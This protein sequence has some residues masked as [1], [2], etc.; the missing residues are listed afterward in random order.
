MLLEVTSKLLTCQ[1]GYKRLYFQKKGAVV[2]LNVA[3]FLVLGGNLWLDFINTE[4]VEHGQPK[5]LVEN[6]ADLVAWAVATHLLE[7][8]G[9]EHLAAVWNDQHAAGLWPIR[10]FRS[11]L[12]SMAVGLVQGKAVDAAIIAAINEE[13]RHK[14]GIV[15]VRQHES[16]FEK[17]FHPMIVEPQQLLAP[18]AES[19]ADFLCYANMAYLKKC[20]NP[21][22]ILYF[23][24]TTKN[25]SRR[26]CSM[27]NCGNRA[28]V[29]AF[30]QRRRAQE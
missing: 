29:A 22:C 20:E 23:Y 12:R 2:I 25:H 27:A 11:S 24:D 14:S 26:W 18:I 1:E 19:A 4:V 7:Q 30:Y 28:K 21:A 15:E 6:S 9:A 5:D 13:L 17:L 10:A 8:A 16:G 3:K